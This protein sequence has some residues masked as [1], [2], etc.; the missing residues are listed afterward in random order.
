MDLE[1]QDSSQNL[2]SGYSRHSRNPNQIE[3]ESIGNDNEMSE[4]YNQ[5]E[6]AEEWAQQAH[7]RSN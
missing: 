4:E 5:M 7:I 3:E 2:Q 1:D 6:E